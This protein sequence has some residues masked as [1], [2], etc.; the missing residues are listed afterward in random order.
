MT[1]EMLSY[2]NKIPAH[3]VVMVAGIISLYLLSR[4]NFFK[5]I[6]YTTEQKIYHVFLKSLYHFKRI[7]EFD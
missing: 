6:L 2:I 1:V 4:I 7:R 3:F 5:W